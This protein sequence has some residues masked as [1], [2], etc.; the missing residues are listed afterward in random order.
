[1]SIFYNTCSQ[2]TWTLCHSVADKPLDSRSCSETKKW[3]IKWNLRFAAWCSNVSF[4]QTTNCK[5]E[6]FLKCSEIFRSVSCNV[7]IHKLLLKLVEVGSITVPV[8]VTFTAI[9]H[10]VLFLSFSFSY[11]LHGAL[12][13]RYIVNVDLLDPSLCSHLHPFLLPIFPISP[14]CPPCLFTTVLSSATVF[15][16]LLSFRG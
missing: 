4:Q 7:W 3:D 13:N 1:M 14:S 16:S 11:S 2:S 9:Q 10:F 5:C 12:L 8:T 15:L 6:I